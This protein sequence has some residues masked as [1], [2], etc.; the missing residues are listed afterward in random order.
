MAPRTKISGEYTRISQKTAYYDLLDKLHDTPISQG[1]AIELVQHL[2][3]TF[4]VNVG[5]VIFKQWHKG[6]AMYRTKNIILPAT[7]KQDTRRVGFLR[8]GIVVHEFCHLLAL[9]RGCRNHGEVFI[10]TLDELVLYVS[11]YQAQQ[12]AA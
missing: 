11:Q 9:Q 2:A 4:Q 8:T 12:Q 3:Q 6:R 5:K 10:K 7:P 1:T